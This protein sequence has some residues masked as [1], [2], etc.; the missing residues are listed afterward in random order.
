MADEDATPETESKAPTAQATALWKRLGMR[1]RIVIIGALAALIGVLGWTMSR[2]E[3]VPHAVL[4]S[5]LSQEE[6]GRVIQELQARKIAYDVEHNGT[7]ITVPEDQV[8]ELRLT[9]AA[10]GGAPNGGVG[11]E[12]FDKQSFGTTSFV[13]RMNYRRALEGE[14]ARTIKSLST[15]DRARVHIAM[16]KRSLYSR[17]DEPPSASV[18]LELR[19]G[20]QLSRAQRRGIVNLV[21][22]SIDG[23]DPSRVTL[24]DGSGNALAAPGS[25]GVGHEDSMDLERTLASRVERMLEAVV[26]PGN[27]AVTVTAELDR[28]LIE[29]TEERYDQ[30]A[31]SPPMT[32]YERHAIGEAAIA[33]VGGVAGAQGNLPG[34]AG[35]G[36]GGPGQP[37]QRLDEVKNFEV[38]KIV[39]HSIGPK[40]RLKRLHLAVLVD[41]PK[42]DSGAS[43][44]RSEADLARIASIAREAAGLDEERGDKIEVHSVPFAHEPLPELGDAV[45]DEPVGET[46]TGIPVPYLAAAGAGALALFVLFFMVLRARRK[47]KQAE[48]EEREEV[49]ATTL[50]MTVE[51][52]EAELPGGVEDPDNQDITPTELPENATLL[53]RVAMAAASDSEL[54]ARVFRTWL[55]GPKK[56]ADG[57]A[58]DDEYEEAA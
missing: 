15:V 57:A 7:V 43:V 54:A 1:Q 2:G 48:E 16:G 58:N 13:E 19:A 32:S 21:A 27:V 12:V 34:T 25:E 49:V 8:D 56:S 24:V 17:E 3:T 4:Y 10:D 6:A 11:F 37:G 28:E 41:E 47:K 30:P 36:A 14:L 9:L 22:S 44:A 52:L 46:E 45:E 23:L 18:M 50:P 39:Q 5:E 35:P 26:A 20:Q 42:D 51:E 29:R 31:E 53:D 33:N 38:N 55:A 40:L